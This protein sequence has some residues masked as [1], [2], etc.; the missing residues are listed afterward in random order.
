MVNL[1]KKILIVEDEKILLSLYK[2]KFEL[3]G[4]LV[5]TA[6]D[7]EEGLLVT[8]QE[9]PDLILLDIVMPKMDGLTMAQTLRDSGDQTP[10]IFLTNYDDVDRI[11]KAMEIGPIDYLLKADWEPKDIVARVKEKLGLK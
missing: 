9:S 11:S 6:Q 5:V 7:G 4:F 1:E 2:E 8:K 10:I 3:E